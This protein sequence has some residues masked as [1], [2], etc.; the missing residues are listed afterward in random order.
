[1][2]AS[3]TFGD[4]VG[5]EAL[6]I[7]SVL[8]ARGF[9]SDI[10]AESTDS[11]LSGRAR[12]LAEYEPISS[13]ENVLLLHF[14][15]GSGASALARRLPDKLVLRYHNITPAHWFLRDSPKV[16]L[17]CL[18]GRRELATLRD[19]TALALGVSEF[20]RRE[21]DELGFSR[22]DVLPYQYEPGRLATPPNPVVLEMFD[23]DLT[24]FLCVGR[25]M[26]HKKM[27]DV[28]KIFKFYQHAIDRRSRLLFV[29]Q[30]HDFERY[31][32]RLVGFSDELDLRNVYFAGHVSNEDL[33]AFYQCADVLLSM[34]E[35]EGFCVPL[36]E[37]FQM[38]VPVIAYDAGAVSATMAGA[39]IL[40]HEKRFDEIAELASLLLRD[41]TLREEIVSSQYRALDAALSGN[42]GELVDRFVGVVSS[43][44]PS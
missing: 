32:E 22:T 17:Q 1:M 11:V 38:G 24:N 10:F 7:Q 15:I 4:A 6:N 20:N 28:M 25:V 19:R 44:A 8:R 21:L 14:S 16:A 37:A 34:S 3:L 30:C 39:G 13:P 36:L 2:V 41:D 18:S 29:G 12:E 35:H 27:E 23:D 31:Y 40:V 26:P 5:N 43:S 33:V 9:E 42:G